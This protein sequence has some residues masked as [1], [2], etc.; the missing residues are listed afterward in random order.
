MITE[1]AEGLQAL[2]VNRWGIWGVPDV[3]CGALKYQLDWETLMGIRE[4]DLH[5]TYQ[6]EPPGCTGRAGNYVLANSGQ[7]LRSHIHLP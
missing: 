4:S 1:E 6:L 3:H 5:R 7:H 2:C